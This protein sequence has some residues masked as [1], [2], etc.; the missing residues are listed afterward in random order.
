[1]DQVFFGMHC[2]K[3]RDRKETKFS[4]WWLECYCKL[5]GLCGKLEYPYVLLIYNVV[6]MLFL[7]TFK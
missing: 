2:G 4:N 5:G 3:L 6:Q 7:Y 1:M